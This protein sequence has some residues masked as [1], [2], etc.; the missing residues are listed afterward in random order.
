MTRL[1]QRILRKLELSEDEQGDRW[2]NEDIR[3]VPPERQTWGPLQFVQLWFLINMNMT[4]YQVGSSL[5]AS[6][7]TLPQSIIV[8]L[9]GN[10]L[11][12]TFA[13][14]NSVSG[15]QSHLG[16]PIVCRSVWGMWGS[17]FPILNRILTSIVWYGVQAV[18][19]GNMI[20]VCLRS[21]W[22][23]IDERIPNILPAGTGITSAQFVGFALFN[24]ICC[25][26]IWFRPGQLRPY[27]H[28]A[29]LIVAI[30]LFALL[31]WA[32]HSSKGYGSVFNTKSTVSGDELGWTMS[33]GIMS[34]IGSIAAGI[35]NQN[36]FTRF[37]KRASH[38]AYTQ[39]ISFMLSS[40]L[41]AVIGVVITAA[42]QEQYGHGKPL[43]NA[44]TL[45]MAIQD[46]DGARGRAA[47]FFLGLVFII[48]QI[49]INVVGNVLAG[50]LDVAS[51][52]PRYVNLRRGAYVLAAL[53][54]LPLPWKQLA[55]GSVFLSVLSAYAVFLGP[56]VGLLVV[57]YYI[58]QKRQFH[59]SDLY[60]GSAKSLYWYNGG[61][62]WRTMGA[63]VLSILPSM[64]GFVYSV[65]PG[66][67]GPKAATRLFSLSFVLGFCLSGVLALLFHW[68]WPVTYPEL[69][70]IEAEVVEPSDDLQEKM[71]EDKKGGQMS[72][73]EA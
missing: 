55:S 12:S 48:S 10:A 42:T 23:D 5:L 50:G 20:Y 40:S 65:S 69:T 1:V 57:H 58:I 22:L 32:V 4:G 35:L 36:D 45:F 6:G 67:K 14:L 13:V 11:A 3:P 71:Y 38:V 41:I 8:I 21:I 29:S 43:W 37:A 52:F 53:S 51:V 9:V 72:V 2:S 28:S 68:V 49:N 73:S 66:L 46:Q 31:G 15:A 62:N 19:G 44:A 25:I 30:T 56:M 34:V 70:V 24:F 33:A 63:W 54:V 47:T 64:P 17:F 27:F 18:I 26:L 39:A 7:L 59:V 60:E 61:V 16:F